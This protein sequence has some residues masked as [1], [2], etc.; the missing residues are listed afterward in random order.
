[1]ASTLEE[2][3]RLAGVSRS[4]VSRVI[5][6]SPKV[7]PSTREK[8]WVAVESSGYQ[9]HAAARSLVTNRTR[10]IGLIVPEALTIL[11]TDPFFLLLIQGIAGRCNNHQYH[12]MLSLF[13]E[14]RDQDDPYRRV[15]GSG[16]LDGV[17]IASTTL[18]DPLIPR[19]RRDRVPFV[20]VGR[21]PDQ[22]VS[23]VDVDNLG[24]ARR[25]VEHLLRS[26][27]R[28]IATIT[29]PQRM[30]AGADR[31]TG[32][33][34][35]LRSQGLSVDGALV[36]EGDFTEEGGRV[37]M[38]SLLRQ[39]PDAVFVAS[40]TMALGALRALRDA[41]MRVPED[42]ALVG[43]DDM[44]YAAT[45]AP[46]LTTVRQP[47]QRVGALAFEGLLDIIE[48]GLEPVRRLVVP[49]ELIV[50]ESCGAKQAD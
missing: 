20:S 44:P 4:T 35:A 26:G 27:Y 10:I 3:A 15:V 14:R 13:S 1:M 38:E 30:I 19:L 22:E 31:L 11:F 2:V 42:I 18:D 32:Y 25:A 36:A 48:N 39:E 34:E 8:V 12:L 49:T 40:D 41:G 9:P 50:R 21:Y 6:D 7:S 33:Q 5:N 43:F 28:R 46:P 17:I 45:A 16:Y 29:G 47:V 37:G 24:G 23:Y